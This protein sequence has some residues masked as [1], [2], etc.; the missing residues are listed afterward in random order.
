LRL[1]PLRISSV[2][3][4]SRAAYCHFG[5]LRKETTAEQ[6][7]FF[8]CLAL[9][10][11]VIRKEATLAKEMLTRIHTVLSSEARTSA[12]VEE[13]VKFMAELVRVSISLH[14]CPFFFFVCSLLIVPAATG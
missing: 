2:F 9:A 10:A 5:S 13:I 11:L 8:V 4:S 6:H 7:R 14:L 1:V 12:K 3:P